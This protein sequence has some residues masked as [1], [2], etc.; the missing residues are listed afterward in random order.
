MSRRPWKP[1]RRRASRAASRSQLGGARR[2]RGAPPLP[3]AR[4]EELLGRRGRHGLPRPPRLRLDAVGDPRQRV[5]AACLLRPRVALG[6]GLRDR[7]GRPAVAVGA[8]RHGARAGRVPR[9]ATAR[10]PRTS[11]SPRQRSSRST[12]CSSGTRRRRAPTCCSRCSAGCR[13][14]SSCAASTGRRRGPSPPGRRSGR[15]HSRRTTSRRSSSRPRRP[16]SCYKHRHRRAV[17]LATGG[18]R[19]MRPRAPAARPRAAREPRWIAESGFA[20]RSRPDP[21]DLPRRLRGAAAARVRGRG[22]R[23][24]GCSRRLLAAPAAHRRRRPAARAARRRSR[25]GGRRDPGGCLRSWAS[26]TSSTRT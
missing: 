14:S 8:A 2:G 15:S 23:R 26:T 1:S 11:A 25:R 20:G 18:D 5:D 6:A 4:R 17:W 3:D 10:L 16:G 7:R 21:G 24:R 13:C 9:R 22:R 19:G 12:R